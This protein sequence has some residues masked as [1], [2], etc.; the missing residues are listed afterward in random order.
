[1]AFGVNQTM[2]DEDASRIAS[3]LDRIA[4]GLDQLN[5]L[6]QRK[7]QAAKTRI[8]NWAWAIGVIGVAVLILSAIKT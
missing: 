1:M 4:T 8:P 6:L 5:E 2:K 3:S 7:S